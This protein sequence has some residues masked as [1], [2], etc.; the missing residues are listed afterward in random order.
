M[1]C[2]DSGLTSKSN[3]NQ[4]S[5]PSHQVKSTL[6][7]S[8]MIDHAY[9]NENKIEKS[10]RSSSKRKTKKKKHSKDKTWL[11]SSSIYPITTYR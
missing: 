7:N 10:R 9:D 8:S 6:A 4:Y 2:I 11:K 1:S 3:R 5:F